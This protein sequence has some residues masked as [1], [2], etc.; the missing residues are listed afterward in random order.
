MP[1]EQPTGRARDLSH[2]TYS[3]IVVALPAVLATLPETSW[4]P[5]HTEFRLGF[6]S[7][8]G[9]H[10][11]IE[12]WVVAEQLGRTAARNILGAEE[13]FSAVPFFWSRHYDTSV[14]HVGFAGEWDEAEPI[15][16]PRHGN[17][18]VLLRKGGRILAVASVGDP[19]LSLEADL[20]LET[21]DPTEIA[22]WERRLRERA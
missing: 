14:H 18:A 19:Q 13:R 7:Q 12:H 6:L 2:G 8:V 1:R 16:D 3:Q 15:G 21:A 5:L 10:V 4:D 17:C 9:E 11:R 22:D 20:A